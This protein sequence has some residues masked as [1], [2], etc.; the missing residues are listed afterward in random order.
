[1]E[2][3]T[4]RSKNCQ[5]TR[6]ILRGHNERYRQQHCL[7]AEILYVTQLMTSF[8]PDLILAICLQVFGVR[9]DLKLELSQFKF[10]SPSEKP[11]YQVIGIVL[12]ILMIPFECLSVHHFGELWLHHWTDRDNI[13]WKVQIF[14][15]QKMKRLTV[16]RWFKLPPTVLLYVYS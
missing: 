4:Y 8:D 1:M 14:Y 16:S 11:L 15:F 12:C 6:T 5:R 13:H 9:F 3:I 10:R 2:P 7:N